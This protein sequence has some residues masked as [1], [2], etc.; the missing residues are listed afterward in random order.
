MSNPAYAN[1][2]SRFGRIAALNEAAGMLHWDASA[3]M[4]PGGGAARGEQLATLAGL[5][6]E[7][8]TAPAVVEDLAVAEAAGEWDSANLALMRRAHARATALPTSLV[9]A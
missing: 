3:M 1:L 2:K 6:H 9:E 8:L 7:L 4:P 5:A